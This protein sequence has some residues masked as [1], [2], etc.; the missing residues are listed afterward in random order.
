L[1]NIL[2][3]TGLNRCW[4]WSA[5]GAGTSAAAALKASSEVANSIIE[6]VIFMAR[7]PIEMSGNRCYQTSADGQLECDEL[8]F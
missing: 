3:A 1:P 6:I 8:L 4:W 2:A 7:Y 5:T